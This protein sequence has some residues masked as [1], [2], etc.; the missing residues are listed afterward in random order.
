MSVTTF[1]A[2][3]YGEPGRLA[4]PLVCNSNVELRSGNDPLRMDKLRAVG[5]HSFAARSLLFFAPR[6]YNL[7]S[8]ELK[9]IAFVS[10]KERLKTSFW[11]YNLAMVKRQMKTISLV[12]VFNNFLWS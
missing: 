8:I 7:L 2:F 3:K 10:F 1:K 6:L 11:S 9:S 5:G 12:L 4:G